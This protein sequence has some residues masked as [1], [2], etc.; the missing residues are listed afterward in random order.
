M[1]L[2]ERGEMLACRFLAGKGYKI[3]EK[4]YRCPLGEIDVI[5][6]KKGKLAFVEIKTRSSAR[7]GEPAEAVDLR[8]QKKLVRLARWYLKEKQKSDGPAFFAVVSVIWDGTNEPAVRLI[9]NAFG[10]PDELET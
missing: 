7:L 9:E 4:N 6:E 2:G 1:T 3:L 8:K 10:I 5:A